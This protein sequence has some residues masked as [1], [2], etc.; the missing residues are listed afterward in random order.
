[1]PNS[2]S[3][4]EKIAVVDELIRAMRPVADRDAAASRAIDILKA[5]DSDIR[6]TVKPKTTAHQ[7]LEFQVNSAKKQNATLGYI[8]E[9]H[10]RAVTT[11]VIAHW[12]VINLALSEDRETLDI[13]E[14]IRRKQGD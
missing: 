9:G 11:A 3:A 8:D 12:S 13:P 7:A 10:C 5:I 1:M 4:I 14:F 2:Y 6:A